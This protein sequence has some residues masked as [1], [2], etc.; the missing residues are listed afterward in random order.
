ML[1]CPNGAPPPCGNPAPRPAAVTNQSVAVLYFG[2]RSADTSDAYLADG[3]TEGI[4][5]GLSA[6][7]RIE[8]RSTS[9]VDRLRGHTPPPDSAGRVLRVAHL[10]SGNVA[11]SGH[12]LR[13]SVELV[14]A[15]T[16]TTVWAG[17]FDR[18]DADLFDIQSAIADTVSRA[19]M[20]RLLPRARG[21]AT[22]PTVNPAAYD[23]FLQG[24]FRLARRTP[25]DVRDA[26]THYER[27]L[28]LDPAFAA[29]QARIALAYAVALD[30]GWP[31]FDMSSATR[32]GL[33]AS[34]RAIELDSLLPDAW[35]ARGYV[36]RF[37]NARTYAGVR[38]AFRRA[39]RLSP[40][41][42]EAR[43][44]YGWALANMGLP[45]SAI[46]ELKRSIQLDPERSVT[47]FTLAW[48]LVR[49]P[50][51]LAEAR[52]QL[53]SGILMDPAV[54]SL[55]GMRAWTLLLEGDTAGARA[56]IREEHRDDIR[57][58]GSA[59]VAMLWQAGD[60][61]AARDLAADL[62]RD[63]PPAPARVSWGA[64]WAALGWAGTRDID[65]A[66]DI[67]ERIE[68]QGLTVWWML[69]FPGFD[70]I[71]REPRFARFEAELAPQ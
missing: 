14:R 38:E 16:G 48:V 9:A 37:A 2:S 29:A 33:A 15:A 57:I 6:D 31:N 45:D 5:R 42:A 41:D 19:I 46:A 70:P 39:I 17:Q 47:R 23:E 10:V 49:T 20:G 52:T 53:D 64:A 68:P 30:W 36:L 18:D 60:T 8:V 69:Q 27:A 67:L 71:R 13:V 51:R 63:W 43:L 1:Q 7:P 21:A 50:R 3:L 25:T 24:N 65:R 11:R 34:A 58:S 35:T 32:A 26:I 4:I 44:Q 61:T 56:D 66:M 28:Q 22:R 40:R 54:L 62:G 12:R 59:R 55:R